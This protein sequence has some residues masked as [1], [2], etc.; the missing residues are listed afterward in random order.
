MPEFRRRRY[1]C[2]F[3][4]LMK[5]TPWLCTDSDELRVVAAPSSPIS[6]TTRII[7]ETKDSRSTLFKGRGGVAYSVAPSPHHPVRKHH[8]SQSFVDVDLKDAG[9]DDGLSLVVTKVSRHVRGT[10]KAGDEISSYS[11]TAVC[12]SPA[13]RKSAA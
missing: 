2:S 3:V 1:L 4:L 9:G 6:R 8:P 7:V 12:E 13:L 10:W 11:S 5:F